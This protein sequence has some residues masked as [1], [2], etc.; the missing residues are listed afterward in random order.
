MKYALLILIAAFIFSG[1]SHTIHERKK[2]EKDPLDQG[3][4]TE[5]QLRGPRAAIK[6]SF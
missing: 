4:K 1:C 5:L 3:S 6:H 2:N